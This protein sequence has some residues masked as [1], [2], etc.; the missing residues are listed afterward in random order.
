MYVGRAFRF[1]DSEGNWESP[2]VTDCL[3][4]EYAAVMQQVHNLC[5]HD[6]WCK[7]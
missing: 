1:C 3:S 7:V 5:K 6:M 2:V 4:F